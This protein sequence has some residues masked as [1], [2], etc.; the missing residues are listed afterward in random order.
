[1]MRAPRW[2]TE[3]P[4]AHRGLHTAAAG[5]VENTP[6]SFAAAMAGNYAI[7]CDLQ[8]T[9]D[10]EA[11]VF[12]DDTLDRLTTERGPVKS[13]SLA[14]LQNVAFQA[15]HDRMP[16][17]GEL[18]TLVNGKVPLVIELKSHWDG[19][20]RL[21]LCALRTL[22]SYD[23]PYA[24]MSFDPDIV[25]QLATHAP[26]VTRGITAD[27]GTDPYYDILPAARRE[28]LQ[29]FAHLPH[30]RPHFA[31]FDFHDLPFAPVKAFRDAGH[32]V[33]TWTIRTAAEARKAL[34]HS[35][36]ITFEGFAA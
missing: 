27:R 3:R 33:I 32:P 25:E 34:L 6:S 35:D 23:G 9:R 24:V 15:G 22:E 2:L 20:D 7:E 31:S 1:M 21:T 5:I 13:R 18:L 36:Q 17:L 19:D 4:I 8:L 28:E 14:E 26:D 30:T 12:H 16:S 10:G 11:V 29:R